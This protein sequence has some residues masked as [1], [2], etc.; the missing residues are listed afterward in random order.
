[1]DNSILEDVKKLLGITAETTAF[2]AELIIHINSALTSTHQLGVSESPVYI[3]DNKTKW[4]ALLGV[5]K[6]VELVKSLIFLKVK[7]IFDPPSQYVGGL[8]QK[9]ISEFEERIIIQLE[10]R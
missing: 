5:F 1:M 6:D 2:D 8:I 10:A 9:Q 4:S 7:L 3:E